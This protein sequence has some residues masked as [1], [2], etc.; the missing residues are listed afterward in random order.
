MKER[1]IYHGSSGTIEKPVYLRKGDSS[2]NYWESS[3]CV[4]ISMIFKKAVK[5]RNY[6]LFTF[7]EYFGKSEVLKEL[8]RYNE[9]II[10]QGELYIIGLLIEEYPELKNCK[11]QGYDDDVAEWLG[12]LYGYLMIEK[13]SDTFIKKIDWEYLYDRY[14]TLHTQS[15]KYVMDFIID[16]DITK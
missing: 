11:K 1:I 4:K 12:Y 5:L 7:I 10:S 13:C 14:D 6:D 8:Y 3:Y 16:E 15:C 9:A 2:M